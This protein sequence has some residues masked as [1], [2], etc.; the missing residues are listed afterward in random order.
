MAGA[1]SQ[2]ALAMVLT[3]ILASGIASTSLR[4]AV[5]R[6]SSDTTKTIV[7]GVLQRPES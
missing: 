5:T 1:E 2:S 6:T 7:L 3:G 4:A